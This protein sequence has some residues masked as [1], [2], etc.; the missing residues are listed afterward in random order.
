MFGLSGMI[1]WLRSRPSI[2]N[3]DKAREI[4][5]GSWA[6]SSEKANQEL[7]FSPARPLDTRLAQTVAWYRSQGW[8]EGGVDIPASEQANDVFHHGDQ[9]HDP[10]LAGHD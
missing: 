9:G 1:A 2:I 3:T 5:A 10:G 7:G 8:L 6:C 4:L